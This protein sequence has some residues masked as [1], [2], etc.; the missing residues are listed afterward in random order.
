MK[1][2]AEL[3]KKQRRNTVVI[4]VMLVA[5][6]VIGVACLFVGSSNKI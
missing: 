3:E 2:L 6:L 5:V 1:H 4:L